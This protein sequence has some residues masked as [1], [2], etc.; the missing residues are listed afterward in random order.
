MWTV[1]KN[2]NTIPVKQGLQQ[3]MQKRFMK[4]LNM[5][6]NPVWIWSMTLMRATTA[7]YAEV[8]YFEKGKVAGSGGSKN[9]ISPAVALI[10]DERFTT[11]CSSVAFA[12]ASPICKS[13]PGELQKVQAVRSQ[14]AVLHE[15]LAVFRACS[16]R[17]EARRISKPEFCGFFWKH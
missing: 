12:W 4:D 3:K 17:G 7:A 10:N 15:L 8:D 1:V 6:Y 16:V 14:Q 5:R 9:G 2:I 13:D 11:T